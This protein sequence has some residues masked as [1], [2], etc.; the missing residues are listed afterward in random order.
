MHHNSS[1][2]H[3]DGE[4]PSSSHRDGKGSSLSLRR[5]INSSSVQGHGEGYQL[6]PARQRRIIAH[7]KKIGKDS[8]TTLEDGEGSQLILAVYER[9]PAY[10]KGMRKDPRGE[11]K[12]F[13][14][15]LWGNI[16]AQ[17]DAGCQAP[18]AL[19]PSLHQS[20]GCG[21]GMGARGSAPLP[22][23]SLCCMDQELLAVGL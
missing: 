23:S 19:A 20:W 9:I 18:A 22:W 7:P 16:P 8:Q 17:T 1:K 5:G 2:A 10:P 14:P 11:R 13:A 3:R 21:A 15:N 12:T 4:R 6:C